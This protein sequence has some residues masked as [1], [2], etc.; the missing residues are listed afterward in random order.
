MTQAENRATGMADIG[1]EMF[2]LVRD[3]YPICRSITGEG[4]RATLKRVRDWIP[5]EVM[6]V[7]TGT[8][9]FDWT[10]PREWNI[11]DAYI[12]DMDGN[13]VVDFRESN[14]HV[15]NYSVPVD[16][17]ID[18]ATLEDHLFS[19]PDQPELVPY[20]T[21]YYN[22][23]WGFCVSHTQRQAMTDDQYRV[24]IDS[25]LEDGSLTYGEVCYPGRVDDEVIFYTHVCHPSL[26]ND[27]LTGIAVTAA[28][29]RWLASL[30]ERR[31][32]YRLVFGPG[33]IGSITWLSQNRDRLCRSRH[34]LILGLLGDP[35]PHTYKR[36]RNGD[37]EIDRVA[38]YV[39]KERSG[40]SRVRDFSPYGYDERQFG[41]PGIN[42]PVGRLTRSVNGEYPEY[43]TSGD[44]LGLVSAGRLAES[45]EVVQEIVRVL[46]ANVRYVNRAPYG[47][48]QLGRRGLYRK[49]GGTEL[50]GRESA[51]LWLLN[52]ADGG[53]SLLDIADRSGVPFATLVAV[54]EELLAADLLAPADNKDEEGR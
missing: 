31:Y 39:L 12:A 3:L 49:T 45:L 17:V 51:M 30:G 18:R 5:L 7:P 34:G 53:N 16:S 2:D 10:V 23:N 24:V 33:T 38:E 1:A 4:V 27:N 42:L 32:S 37:A 22:E 19:L 44:N 47:E 28:L 54:A 29:G 43:H 6:E 11:R 8:A 36:S 26:C 50:E 40:E 20:R 48:P 52:Q 15:L 41:S 21:S 9:V 46:E 25:T 35:A 14:L 13:R